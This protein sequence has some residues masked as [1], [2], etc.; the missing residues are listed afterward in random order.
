MKARRGRCG[1]ARDGREGCAGR[2][3]QI[4]RGERC[5]GTRVAETEAI[6]V[7]EQRGDGEHLG[8]VQ[9]PVSS[10]VEGQLPRAER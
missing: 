5:L 1:R 10:G 7:A 6:E 3:L 8:H 2:H 4:A 9:R